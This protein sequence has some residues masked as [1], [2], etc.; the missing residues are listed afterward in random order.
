[1]ANSK[2]KHAVRK[3]RYIIPLT[4]LALVIIGRLMLPYFLKNYVNKTLNEIPGYMGHVEDIDVA[5]YRGAY[6]IKG[7]KLRKRS[8]RTDTPM[9]DFPKNDISIEWKSLFKGKIVSEVILH[10]PKFN[11]IFEDQETEPVEGE[12]DVD[13]W[14]KALT[15]LVPIDINHF[16][17]HNGTANFVRLAKDPQI[18]MFLENIDLDAT[19]LSNVVNEEKTLPSNLYARANSMGGGNVTLQGNLNL[20]KKIPDMDIEFSLKKANVTA[21]NDLSENYIGVDFESGTFELYSEFAIADGYLKGYLKPMFIDTKI[22]GK[23]EDRSFLGKIWEGFV[24]AVKWLFE[25]KGTGTLAT[26]APIEGDLNNVD[27]STWAT[28]LNI[29]KNAWIKAFTGDIDEDINYEDA[30]QEAQNE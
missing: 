20:L 21:L 7:L 3:K 19:N 27:T 16:N 12:A 23:E 26:R 4:I 22:L 24:G 15:D 30:A 1:M 25:N 5:L 14:T 9:L 17:V 13:D 2:K 28:V 8:A 29:F 10:G 11:Y 6:V 18:D